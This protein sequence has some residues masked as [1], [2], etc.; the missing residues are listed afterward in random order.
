MTKV[1]V[2]DDDHGARGA[3]VSVLSDMGLAVSEAKAGNEALAKAQIEFPA[4]ILLDVQMPVMDGFQVLRRLRQLPATRLTP[5]VMLTAVPEV[6][7]EACSMLLGSTHYIAKPWH[8]DILKETVRVAIREGIADVAEDNESD[9]KP[10]VFTT[11]GKLS[12]LDAMMDGGI[13]LNT[14]TLIEGA[15][16][17]GKSVLCQHLTYGALADG[18]DTGYFTSDLAARSLVAQMESI[19][20]EVYSYHPD[21]LKIY[22]LPKREE[23]ESPES[24][25][26]WVAK[27]FQK[28]PP[29]CEFIVIDA[30]TALAARCPEAAVIDFFMSCKRLCAQGKTVALSVDSYAFSN[31]MFARLGTLC[32]SY[33]S[34]RTEK[35]GNKGVRTLEVRK[36]GT[37]ELSRDNIISFVVEP[38]VGMNIIPYGK[39]RALN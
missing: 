32:D 28:L 20:L 31:E 12:A 8:L 26:S 21:K 37:I 27:Y 17:A 25:L 9:V 36:S 16:S 13:P 35:V 34:L 6:E 5:V 15:S 24:L 3:L 14:V 4:M 10:Q 2:V 29:A 23:N 38:N 18:H 33:L 7:G 30:I 11:G 19:G 1:L 22:P 39:T